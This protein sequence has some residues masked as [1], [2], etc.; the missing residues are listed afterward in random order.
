MHIWPLAKLQSVM[1]GGAAAH[2]VSGT[3]VSVGSL[4]STMFAA[5]MWCCLFLAFLWLPSSIGSIHQAD[6]LKPVAHGACW[7][8]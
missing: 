4:P 5:I 8:C 1:H 6:N 3:G 2:A 7:L